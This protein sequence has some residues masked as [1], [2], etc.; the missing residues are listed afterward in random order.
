MAL[1]QRGFSGSLHRVDTFAISFNFIYYSSNKL[2]KSTNLPFYLHNVGLQYDD[3][4]SKDLCIG[5][6]A[7][8]WILPRAGLPSLKTLLRLKNSKIPL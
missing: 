3:M 5:R 7:L 8:G 2:F 6:V 1:G 4:Y